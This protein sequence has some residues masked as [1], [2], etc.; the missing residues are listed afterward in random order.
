MKRSAKK[1]QRRNQW[2]RMHLEKRVTDCRMSMLVL[3]LLL[4]LSDTCSV[5]LV[6]LEKW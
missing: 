3:L 2:F 1:K 6:K 4:H 5:E